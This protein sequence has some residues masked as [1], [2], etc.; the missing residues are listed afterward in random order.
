MFRRTKLCSSIL[1]AFGGTLGFVGLPA[2]GQQLER[3]EITGSSIKR[4]ESETALPVQVIT[5]QDI[6]KS[7]ASNVEQLMQTISAMSSNQGIAAASASGS[8]T[9]GISAISM[10]GLG[11][12]RTL[13]LLNGR[14]LAPYGVGNVNDSVS[15]DVNS[16]PLSA[17]ERIEVLKDGASSV[18]GSDAIAGVVNFILRKDLQ[19]G[20]LNAEYGDS[21]QGGGSITKLSG[22]WGTGDIGSDRYNLMVVGSYQKEGALF[23]RDRAFAQHSYNVA[24]NNDTTSGNTYPANVAAVDG[25]FGSRNPTKPFGCIAPYSF[26]DPNTG[27]FGTRACRF[28]PASLVTLI[29]ATERLSLFLSGK[30]ALTDNI[31]AFAEASYN[32][33][34]QHTVIQPVP[35]SDQFT[36]PLSNPLANTAPYNL[37][38]TFPSSTIILTSASAFYPTAYIQ[39]L[40]GGATPDLFVRYRAAV[41]GNRDITDISEAPR[42]TLGIRG[43]AA[44]WDFDTAFLHSQSKVRE[45]VNDGYPIYSKVLPLLNSGT[46]NFFGPNT[47]DIDAQLRATNFTGDS[48]RV[49]SSLTSFGAKAS[50]DLFQL[51]GGPVSIAVG[52]EGRVEK[53]LFQPSEELAQ[54]DI[55]GY[56]GNIAFVDKQ[57]KVASLFAETNVTAMKGLEFDA[58]VRY[59]KY[60]GSGNSTTPKISMRWQPTREFLFRGAVGKG[61]R[62]PSLGDLYTPSTTGVSQTGLSDP[63]RCPTTDDGIKDCATQ[64][65]TT[66]GGFA[67]LKS[68]KSNNATVGIV[69]EP[70]KEVSLAVDVFRIKLKDT[71]SNGLPQAVILGDLGK[72]GS[73][74]TRG[75]VDPAYP[76]L[77]GPIINIDQTNLNTGETRLAGIDFDLKGSFPT[78]EY[79]RFSLGFS[80]TYFIKYDTQNPDGTFSS[81]VA[82][83]SQST[84]G[85]VIPRLKTYQSVTWSRNDWDVTLGMNWQSG[86]ED[87]LGNLLDT[88]DP[89]CACTKRRVGAYETYDLQASFS[90]IQN[91]RLTFGVKNL[92]NRIPPYTNQ[93]FSFQSGYDPQY[94]DPR[95]R[96]VYARMSFAFK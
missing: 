2:L 30:V 21:T 31:E 68:E 91:T 65:P 14:R 27:V 84:T 74:V 36:I 4:I 79:G 15:V 13:V 37:Y 86:Y 3:V 93:G 18:Y 67:G 16:I 66:N 29:P 5:R 89:D 62:A 35:I 17:I 43:T 8:T 19:G 92:L 32:K 10:R 73:Y 90:G 76:A 72:Y 70:T 20:E 87:V 9:G 33:N 12:A 28:D 1:I 59:D 23:G 7:G 77:P 50:R 45:Q 46:V 34:T 57:R 71:I 83:L 48:F 49:T 80:G 94:A 39:G 78:P 44:S 75:A 11:S 55:S 47:A 61:F 40:T 52:G 58:A 95:G 64:F 60:Q 63:L 53:Y 96:F 69:L 6:L 22:A 81:N 25:S 56:G 82:N 41:N 54:G 42:V 88:E 38:T 26:V 85:G 51:P 24:E